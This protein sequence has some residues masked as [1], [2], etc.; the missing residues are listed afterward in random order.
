MSKDLNV[1]EFFQSL[2]VSDVIDLGG[3]KSITVLEAD[4][5]KGL[6]IGCGRCPSASICHSS[7]IRLDGDAGV[8][9]S[10]GDPFDCFNGVL[11]LLHEEGVLKLKKGAGAHVV[12]W[13]NE[14]KE[15]VENHSIGQAS[16]AKYIKKNE[17]LQ[18]KVLALCLRTVFETVTEDAEAI[19]N[20]SGFNDGDLNEEKI[21]ILG[22]AIEM[23]KKAS[24]TYTMAPSSLI[25]SMIL[26]LK[27]P[28]MK[29]V[30]ESLRNEW[31]WSPGEF[32]S[33]CENN[34]SDIQ[35]IK[36]VL[37]NRRIKLITQRAEIICRCIGLGEGELTKEKVG[38][39]AYVLNSVV[40]DIVPDIQIIEISGRG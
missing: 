21:A 3:M 22:A 12:Q 40:Q 28:E 10:D 16:F 15:M 18:D 38:F 6:T 23:Y 36:D 27:L 33:F 29:D 30:G 2:E 19:L 25:A 11:P 39:F 13:H 7:P 20:M 26:E 1:R 17:G 31:K 35:K 8:L 34:P 14:M 9:G 37:S 4:K 5:E 32:S 24:L